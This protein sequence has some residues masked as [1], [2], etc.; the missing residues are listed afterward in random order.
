VITQYFDELA[1]V[2]KEH[3]NPSSTCI[4]ECVV[5]FGSEGDAL[6]V[7]DRPWLSHT[8]LNDWQLPVEAATYLMRRYVVDV[9]IVEAL[10]LGVLKIF[11]LITS[12][13]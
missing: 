8:C 4:E 2:L 11:T 1:V 7:K 12:E 9:W 5:D 6:V 13:R 10:E 3:E